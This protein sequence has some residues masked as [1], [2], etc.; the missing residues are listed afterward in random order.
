MTKVLIDRIGDR[1]D[2]TEERDKLE[3]RG[4][5][6]SCEYYNGS[7]RKKKIYSDEG[8]RNI[9]QAA[10]NEDRNKKISDSLLGH[11]VSPETRNKI[12]KTLLTNNKK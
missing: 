12:S 8:L 5:R 3:A 11:E 6:M 2:W 7:D 10:K 4:F 9:Q 1:I